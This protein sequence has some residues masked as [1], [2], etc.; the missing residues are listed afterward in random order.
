[1]GDQLDPN[2]PAAAA[3]FDEN[4]LPFERPPKKG[5]PMRTFAVALKQAPTRTTAQQPAPVAATLAYSHPYESRAALTVASLPRFG[6][7]EVEDDAFHMR[8]GSRFRALLAV[9]NQL[10]ILMYEC[11]LPDQIPPTLRDADDDDG[12][13]SSQQKRTAR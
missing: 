6:E 2:F 13:A 5:N 1:M 9:R 10:D 4:P 8:D 7:V 12:G 11:M 3:S